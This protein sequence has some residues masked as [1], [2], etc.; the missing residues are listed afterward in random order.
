MKVYIASIFA[1][2]DRVALRAEEL[3]ADG[4]T[5]TMR[6]C[7]EM[8]PHQCTIT[9][10]PDEYF[11]E[12]AVFDL[13]DILAADKLVLTVPTDKMMADCT[14]RAM[15]RGG[16]HFESGFMYAMAY[17]RP[18]E[19]ELIIV[20]PRENVFHF[21]DGQSVTSKFPAIRQFNTWEE[22]RTYLREAK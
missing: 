7:Y 16:R 13:E 4:V 10:F 20:G 18:S 11:R 3:K 21:L 14:L 8:V 22:C 17:A 1:D 12:T 19:Y 9:D 5:P 15:A 6:W 2:Q